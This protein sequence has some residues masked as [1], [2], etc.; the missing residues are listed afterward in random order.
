MTFGLF[1]LA[2]IMA[3]YLLFIRG[4]LFKLL[5]FIAGWFGMYIMLWMFIPDSRHAA[6]TTSNGT[7]YTWAFVLPTVAALLALLT[8]KE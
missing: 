8:T 5:F 3:I 4:W 7:G 6:F 1:F 2:I